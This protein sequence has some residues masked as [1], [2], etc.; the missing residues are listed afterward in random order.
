[1][2]GS[3]RRKTSDPR[4]YPVILGHPDVVVA[5]GRMDA[6]YEKIDAMEKPYRKKKQRRAEPRPQFQ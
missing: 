4:N 6:Y 3:Y 5:K 2:F 1:M